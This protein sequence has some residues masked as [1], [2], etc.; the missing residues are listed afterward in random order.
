M[1]A[2]KEAASVALVVFLVVGV[3]WLMR[4]MGFSGA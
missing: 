1:D 2:L 3:S 4:R